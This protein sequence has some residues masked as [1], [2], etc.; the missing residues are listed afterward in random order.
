M[1]VTVGPP[2]CL[3]GAFTG[4]QGRWAE[5]GRSTA[6]SIAWER[7]QIHGSED[8]AKREDLGP[9]SPSAFISC[10]VQA[11]I[12]DL[13]KHRVSAGDVYL[14]VEQLDSRAG[15]CAVAASEFTDRCSPGPHA[16]EPLRDL[17]QN[18]QMAGHPEMTSHSFSL[19]SLGD[20]NP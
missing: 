10:V 6:G 8:V 17:P 9:E 2:P 5:K 4:R 11:H 13:G 15:D 12:S 19:W 1:Q 18:K 14:V 3:S 7:S 16:R 20:S